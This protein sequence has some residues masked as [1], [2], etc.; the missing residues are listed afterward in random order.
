MTVGAVACASNLLTYSIDITTNGDT[1][2][3]NVPAANITNTGGNNWTIDNI[4]DGTNIDITVT[5]TATSCTNTANVTA[6]N[7]NCPMVNAPGIVQGDQAYCIGGTVPTMEVSVGANETVDWYTAAT[8]GTA[9]VVGSTTHQPSEG[10]LATGA[11]TFFAET[12]NTVNGCTSNVRTSITITQNPLPTVVAN[13]TNTTVCTGQQVTLTGSGANTYLWSNGITDGVAFAPVATTTYTVTGTDAN[14]CQ[15]TDN[16]TITVTPLPSAP[17][18]T[19]PVNYCQ[20]DTAS[21]L[22]ATGTNLLWYNGPTGGTGSPTAPTPST[23]TVGSISYWVSQTVSGCEGPREEIQVVVNAIPN[24]PGVTSPAIQCQNDAAVQ[25][26]AT[27]SNLLWYNSATG[28]TGSAT[29]PTPSTASVGDT[30]YW[31]SQ[32][33]NGCEGP[34]AEIISRINAQPTLTVGAVAC[35]SNLLTYSIDITTNGDTVTTN[36]PA[37]N[38]TNTGGNNWTIDNIPDGTNIDITVTIT[39][40]SC[41]NTANVT[42]PNCNCPMVNA[43][44][45]VQG[46]QAYCIGGTVPTMEVSVGANETVDWYTA[47]TGGTAIVVGS[48]THQPLEGSLATGANTFFAE[49]RNTVNGCTSNV[50][51][52]IT[53]TQNPLPNA[54][55]A[56]NVPYCQN[57]TAVPLTAT[58][59]NLLWYNSATGGTGS[60]SA[61]TPST[62]I[63]R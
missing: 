62:A 20:N 44:G 54:P 51:T 10:S 27:G 19:T 40:T 59:T 23:T 48:T 53:I 22:T 31:V 7:C 11:N 49:T 45:I 21:P 25:L 50:R 35:A 41:T 3:T 32:T 55:G 28:G 16:I 57:D 17:G 24:A 47:A 58:G 26:T 56:S 4:P 2:T 12:R 42:A 30:S 46:D 18:V 33:V 36:V 34:R 13:A 15:N 37:A 60:G 61:P 8:G 38:I 14:G 43:P 9:I 52:S 29:A 1:V 63:C 6:P 5:I 39:A